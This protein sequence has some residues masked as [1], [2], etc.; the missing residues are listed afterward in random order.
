MC[1]LT[2]TVDAAVINNIHFITLQEVRR[3][4]GPLLKAF[5]AEVVSVC[6]IGEYCDITCLFQI[7]AL[8]KRSKVAETACLNLYRKLIDI[9]GWYGIHVIVYLSYHILQI[10]FQYYNRLFLFNSD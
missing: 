1:K 4:A 5:Q 6:S 9:P 2:A 3:A 10:P 7:D 8:S